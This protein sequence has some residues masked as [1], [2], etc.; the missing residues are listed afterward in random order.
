MRLMKTKC[1]IVDDEPLAIS[2]IKNHISKITDIE[3]VS[4]CSDAIEAFELL[5]EQ[6]IDLIFLDIEMPEITG[7][8]F[9]KSIKNP[10]AVIFTTAYRNYAIEAFDLDIID[11][12]LKPIEFERF[13]RAIDRY[14]AA[15][16]KN[17]KT[18]CENSEQKDYLKLKAN[19]QTH[20]VYFNEIIYVEN[21]KDY[22]QI[23]TKSKKII[24]RM[25]I[26]D[27]DNIL[28]SDN[29]LRIHR[30]YIVSIKA[31]E[32][33]SNHSI[34]ISNKELPVSRSYRNT[35]FKVLNRE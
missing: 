31:I 32:S 30:S 6:E 17:G 22:L 16:V 7:I 25:A 28:P 23:F 27:L 29:F 14:Y 33:F 15:R 24:T 5:Q 34:K 1:I 20:I 11:Y 26:R 12:L 9:L 2:A 19:K 3:I 8:N 18:I 35:V 4:T 21:L 13:L 10:P